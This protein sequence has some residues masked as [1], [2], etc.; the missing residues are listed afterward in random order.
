MPIIVSEPVSERGKKDARRHREKQKE[1]IKSRLPEIISNESIITQRKG[2]VVK[3]PIK[4]IDIPHFKP[5]TGN[6]SPSGMGQGK[7]GVGDIIGKKKLPDGSEPGE[8]GQEPGEDYIETEIPIEELLELMFEDLG[9]PK[10][11]EK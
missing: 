3:I 10:L 1:A 4:S 7:G 5:N 11:E 9:L 8:A 6:G 2:K